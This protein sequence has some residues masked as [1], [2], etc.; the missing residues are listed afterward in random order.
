MSRR[1]D[2]KRPASRPRGELRGFG[3][4]LALCRAPGD[5]AYTLADQVT[6]EQWAAK[7]HD[8]QVRL[9]VRL[10]RL[11][12][13][14]TRLTVER[15]CPKQAAAIRATKLE[16]A[17]DYDAAF[18]T[19]LA[20]AQTYMFL[21]R[22]T[23]DAEIKQRIRTVSGKLVE[24]AEKIKQAN[25]LSKKPVTKNDLSI[26]AAPSN[27]PLALSRLAEPSLR[28]EEQDAVLA[29]GSLISGHRLARWTPDDARPLPTR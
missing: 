10:V 7:Y 23:T 25:K 20:A 2:E 29:S 15:C 14:P 24:R 6:P 18:K 5:T 12:F 9:L 13:Y 4:S 22:H 16:L 1:A 21:L 11:G 3:R 17:R 27:T 8:A 28:T 26:G 19:Y